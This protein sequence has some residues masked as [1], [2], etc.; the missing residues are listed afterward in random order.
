MTTVRTTRWLKTT[1][2]LTSAFGLAMALAPHASANPTGGQV[3]AGEATISAPDTSTLQIDQTSRNAVIEWRSFDIDAGETT[4]FVQPDNQS[5]TL[6]RVTGETAPSHILGTLEANGNVAI[7]NPDGILF[8]R[9]ARVDV[10]GLI[11]T[12]HDIENDDF[13]AGRFQFNRPGNPSA[14]IVNE[15]SISI[16]DYGLGAFVAPG[17]RNSGVITARLGSVSLASGNAFSLDL[18][19]DNLVHLL[20]DDEIAAEVMDVATGK[21]VTDLVK[22][23]GRISAD[24][25]TVA[26]TAATAR[27]A[28]NSVV[29]NSG[30]IE[31]NSVSRR[32]GKI[33]LG[34]LT[35]GTKKSGTPPQRVKVSGQLLATNVPIPTP[36]PDPATGGQIA[37]L[38]ERIEVSNATI[39]VSGEGGGGTI[40]IG[41]DYMG[42]HGDP[43]T[44]GAYGIELEAEAVATASSVAIDKDTVIRANA[45]E[46]GDG[47]KVVVWADRDT[48][49]EGAIQA[50]GGATG[51]DGGFVEVSGRE[52][53]AFSGSVDIGALDG[54]VGTLLLD[55][56]NATIGTIGTWIITPASIAAALASGNVIVT[57]GNQGEGDGDLTVAQAIN[58]STANSLTLRAHRDINVNASITNSRAADV[59]LR[60]DGTGSGV[61]TVTFAPGTQVSTAGTV[62][63]FYNPSV[64]PAGSGVNTTSYVNPTE[65]FSAHLNGGGNSVYM[66]VNSVYDLQ[67]VQNDIFAN[68]ALGRD[69]DAS[70][71]QSW[72]SGQGFNPIALRYP[73]GGVVGFYGQFDGLGHVV[74]DLYIDRPTTFAVGLFGGLGDPSAVVR[75]LTLEG[76]SITGQMDVGGVAG[77]V[78][79][80]VIDRVA[81]SGTVVGRTWVGGLV[82][83]N[84]F[85]SVS[86][87]FSSA[88]VS[89]RVVPTGGLIGSNYGLLE[90]SYAFGSVDGD[91]VV[92]GLVGA[93]F[94][95]IRNSYAANVVRG[96]RVG[97]IVGWNGTDGLT[98][99]NGRV[100]RSFFDSTIAGSVPACAIN[101]AACNAV[102]ILSEQMN[103]ASTFTGAGWDFDNVWAIGPSTNDGYPYLRWQTASL[104]LPIVLTPDLLAITVPSQDIFN[105]SFRMANSTIALPGDTLRLV[106]LHRNVGALGLSDTGEKIDLWDTQ[107]L[108]DS[109]AASAL[110]PYALV[111]DL[112][113]TDQYSAYGWHREAT[114]EDILRKQYS[115]YPQEEVERIIERIRD[116]GFYAAVYRRDGETTFAFRG[117]QSIFSLDGL[118][119]WFGNNFPQYVF[120]LR[121]NNQYALAKVLTLFTADQY[122]SD[123]ILTGHSLG[124]G[125]AQYVVS[126]F[127]PDLPLKAITFNASGLRSPR[128]G[129]SSDVINVRIY[130]DPVSSALG[131]KQLGE[132]KYEFTPDL[133]GVDVFSVHKIEEVI[134]ALTLAWDSSN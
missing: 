125:L 122:G 86:Q 121:N 11:A 15:G 28:V 95:T 25:G 59:S 72:N 126:E 94:G 90:N 116:S 52:R 114:W 127:S 1:T 117:S 83:T 123:L 66:L 106:K 27:R 110:L 129:Q 98:N 30:I 65:D 60:A 89:G 32:G 46:G 78:G 56:A 61:G 62:S 14:S 120:G 63:L 79:N 130:G 93:N 51:G 55:P 19:G 82:G 102:G 42:G 21:A 9:D 104:S 112:S 100:T 69:I 97:G 91:D 115:R 24:G 99:S 108:S 101:E 77:F 85:G 5:W 64:N 128:Y 49:L 96:R 26:L 76:A 3:A 87:S 44:I 92:G 107:K 47:G 23:E 109:D 41:G 43:A 39:D 16:A 58:W 45:L 88:A 119:D 57:T 50:R 71:T 4:R 12:T 131:G 13:M 103:S 118:P 124:G 67:N 74:S 34:A 38:G 36:R 75:N 7:V 37:I 20:V 6:N 31:A 133:T 40:L 81:V 29:N 17:V 105:P 35:A 10:G 54:Q 70:E 111:S 80:G 8:G 113:Y 2:A 132:G 53:L 84:L 22:N 48:T 134:S 18:Y 73:N 33:V 68:Y